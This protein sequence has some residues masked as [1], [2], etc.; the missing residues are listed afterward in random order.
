MGHTIERY[1][2][3]IINT[4]LAKLDVQQDRNGAE[5]YS[6]IKYAGI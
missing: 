2:T 6:S 4:T 3:I 1:I 5:V